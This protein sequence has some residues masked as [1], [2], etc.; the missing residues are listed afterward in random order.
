MVPVAGLT[1]FAVASGYL[2]SLLPLALPHF[3][4][5]PTLAPYL[6]SAFYA[7]MLLGALGSARLVGRLGHRHAFVFFLLVLLGSVLGLLALPLAPAWLGLRLLAGMASAG[8]YV[9]VESWLLLVDDDRQRA[10]RLGLYMA[11]LYGGSAL[12][13]L[14]IG[15]LGT[16]GALPFAAILTLLALAILPPMLVRRGAP[17]IAV[18][19]TL[20]M[21]ALRTI[22]RP[23][24]IGCLVSGLVLGPLYGLMP[25]YIHGQPALSDHTGQLMAL[26]ILGGMLVQPVTG[27]L[28]PRMSKTLLMAALC[29]VGTLAVAGML[30]ATTLAA[31]AACYLLLGAC[32]FALYPV[33]ITQ[34]CQGQES[35][36]IVAITELMLL[37]Y[38]IGSVTGPLVAGQMVP[39]KEGLPLYLGTALAATCIYMLI[40]AARNA[41]TAGVRLDPPSGE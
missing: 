24:V 10:R 4:L 27:Y 12:G 34:A 14:G 35:G 31:E 33:A 38:G 17:A 40:L 18:H 2:M 21:G 15:Q 5:S 39:L 22:S 28:S 32:A 8:V 37:C 30:L 19:H 20:P 16:Q 25:L 23:A 41:A 1:L 7:G 3:Q 29:G 36:S 13:Q 6:A 9:V 11:S 26:V